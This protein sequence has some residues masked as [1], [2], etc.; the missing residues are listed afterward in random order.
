MEIVTKPAFTVLGMV[1]RG[2]NGPKFIPPLW[3]RYMKRFDE[4]KNMRKSNIGYGVMDNFDKSTKEFD[5][6]AGIEVEPGTE[7]PESFTIWNIPKQTY[8]VMTCT[9]PTIGE[10]YQFFDREWLPQEGYQRADGPEFE[11]YPENFEKI[12]TDTIY[13]YLPIKKQP[14]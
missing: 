7:A 9:I 5:Y 3:E 4:I 13:L 11:F 2:K 1:K 14:F 10:A 8:A 12:E 6:L